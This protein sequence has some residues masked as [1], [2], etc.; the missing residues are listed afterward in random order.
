ME[1]VLSKIILKAFKWFTLADNKIKMQGEMYYFGEGVE[2]D[3]QKEP[4]ICS[5]RKRKEES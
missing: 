4:G 1:K 3:Y 2:Q 5:S